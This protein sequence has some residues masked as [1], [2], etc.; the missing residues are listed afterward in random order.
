MWSDDIKLQRDLIAQ[1][2]TKFPGM[3]K[4]MIVEFLKGI[5][6]NVF[7]GY[8]FAKPMDVASFEAKYMQNQ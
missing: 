7:Q 4:K 1:V 5:G 2:K 8:Y 6:C 3:S